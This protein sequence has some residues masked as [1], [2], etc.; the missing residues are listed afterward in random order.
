MTCDIE[1]MFHQVHINAEH[2][3]LPRFLWWEENDLSKD[4]VDYRMT[5]LHSSKPRM[6]L[7]ENTVNKQ[8]TSCETISM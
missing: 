8:P 7:R 3:D 5:V 4:P 6:T 2:R 1:G